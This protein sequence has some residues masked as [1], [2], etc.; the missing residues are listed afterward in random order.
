MQC[1]ANGIY[2]FRCHVHVF[3]VLLLFFVIVAVVHVIHEAFLVEAFVIAIVPKVLVDRLVLGLLS[4]G[5]T[6]TV[7]IEFTFRHNE[8]GGNISFG[9]FH[10]SQDPFFVC[11]R[12][13][14]QLH[15]RIDVGGQQHVG[16][17]EK[18]DDGDQ[19]QLHRSGRCPCFRVRLVG[20]GVSALMQDG[21]TQPAIAINVGV[22]N[23][24]GE[25]E[26]WGSKR[27]LRGKSHSALEVA[28]VVHGLL[29]QHHD[30]DVPKEDVVVVEFDVERRDAFLGVGEVFKLSSKDGSG[31]FGTHDGNC[32][33]SCFVATVSRG[34][35]F[36]SLTTGFD[37]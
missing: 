21:D 34:C 29:V 5:I 23:G 13:F 33:I 4:V 10:L 7:G 2:L 12:V 19:H 6:R 8:V 26:C 36:A 1:I 31:R 32:D 22:V 17:F 3:L 27:E 18:G 15:R 20:S 9:S 25:A 30:A 16:V 11:F 35:Y 37:S 28:T 24:G 14:S